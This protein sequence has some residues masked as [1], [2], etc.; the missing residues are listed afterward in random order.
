MINPELPVS[1]PAEFFGREPIVK[2]IFS[3]IGAERPQ[4]IAVI[5]GRKSGKTS[6]LN[7]L[8]NEQV[9]GRFLTNPELYTF[10]LI[11][12]DSVTGG[13][14]HLLRLVTGG[15][16]GEGRGDQNPY[17]SLQK[18]VEA[19]H[20]EGKKLIVLLDDFHLVTGNKE[21]PLEFFS[22]LRSLANNYN[23]A[24]VTTSFLELQQ[25]CVVKAIEE[26]PFFNIFTNVSLGLFSISEATEYLSSILG[27]ARN[28]AEEIVTACG[29][30]PYLL[31]IVASLI[32]GKKVVESEV[33]SSYEKTV[34]PSFVP[35]FEKIVSIL[36][37]DSYTSLK[38]VIKSGTPDVK[39]RHL[40]RVLVHH[41]FL[42]EDGDRIVPC[43]QAF[44]LF[45]RKNLTQS[46]LRGRDGYGSNES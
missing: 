29:P 7:Y 17:A 43:S 38:A 19:I 2:R 44:A 21:Y 16:L 27:T 24:Y 37:K 11:R 1:E 35:Y 39:E 4:S 3:R 45:L 28:V 20:S 14:E 23:V 8:F 42:V 12:S 46:M 30:S 6:L 15:A 5:G 31:K 22:F 13:A 36:P 34:H 40:L 9:R 10:S 41:G 33:A 18:L 25:L 26:S 32:Q